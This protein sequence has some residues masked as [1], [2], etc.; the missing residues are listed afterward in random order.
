MKLQRIVFLI[1]AVAATALLVGCGGGSAWGQSIPSVS[2]KSSSDGYRLVEY[3]DYTLKWR[4]DQGL[5]DF[6]VS[7]PTTGWVGIGFS[8]STK[9]KDANIIIGYVTNGQ[10]TVTDQFGTSAT[11]HRQ[12][13]QLGGKNNLSDTSGTELNGLTTIHFKMPLDSGDGN[14]RLL[15]QGAT[16]TVIL[17]H[18]PDAADD[19]STYHGQ[20]ARLTLIVEL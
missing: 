1:T 15:T 7:Y 8:P 18:G 5:I 10:G 17:A 16:T 9:M 19:V 3:K 13:T 12:D 2:A 6:S 11:Y 14:D 20:D 4:I